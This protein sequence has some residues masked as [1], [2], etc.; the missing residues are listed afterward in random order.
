M[1]NTKLTLKQQ[2]FVAAY[3]GPAQGNA[4]EAA[5]LAGYHGNRVTL[6]AVGSEN[7]RNPL[8]QADLGDRIEGM[9]H[10]LLDV[11]PSKIEAASLGDVS[12]IL[13]IL[14]DHTQLLRQQPLTRPDFLVRSSVKT[15]F[16]GSS[17]NTL[18]WATG[19]LRRTIAWAECSS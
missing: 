16:A 4:T 15:N 2:R 18:N 17:R 10:L 9:I 14:V 5:R 6:A 3:L 12:R 1:P 7:L 13:A 11:L 8:I 19:Y